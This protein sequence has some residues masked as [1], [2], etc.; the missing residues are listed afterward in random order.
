M[1]RKKDRKISADR[2][3]KV[4]VTEPMMEADTDQGVVRP[5]NPIINF[6]SIGS[7]GGNGANYNMTKHYGKG[8][9]D[10]T[11][12]AFYTVKTLLNS[13]NGTEKTKKGYL[14]GGFSELSDYLAIWHHTLSRELTHKDITPEFIE[15]FRGHMLGAGKGYTSQKI[16]YTSVKGLLTAMR[17]NGYWPIPNEAFSEIFPANPYPN[18]NRRVK[19]AKPFSEHEK[20]QL[21]VALK[22]ALKPIYAPNREEPLTGYELTVCVLAIAMQTGINTTPL[23]NMTT[24]S[25]SDHPLKSNRK[26]LTVYK[27]RGNATQLHN[28][29]KSEQ[30]EL[31]QGVKL[32]VAHIIERIT[33]L[34]KSVRDK[35]GSNSLIVYRPTGG[36]GN[37]RRTTSIYDRAL[38]Y[39]IAKLVKNYELIDEDKKTIKVN[40]SRI[41]KTFI[42]GIYELSGENILIAAKSAKHSGTGT[43]DHYL[44]AP[45]KSKRNL[46]LM[47]EIRVKELTS[48]TQPTPT[49]RCKDPIDGDKAP[50]NGTTCADF[51]ACFRCKSFVITGDDLY[52]LYSFYWAIV[53]NR[54]SFGRKDWKRYLRNVMSV[55]D[56]EVE[57]AFFEKG[58]ASH[59]QAERERARVS[60][61]P[62][63][64]NLD[65]LRVG[66]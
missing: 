11:N 62:Y 46:G 8:F 63:W 66:Q 33:A 16:V 57:P 34:N 38:S 32:D 7:K 49:G 50:K 14:S 52:R 64:I 39:N 55:I 44:E 48:D 31:V 6:P 51:L 54:D 15:G 30:V 3:K 2:F 59:L 41:R 9:D 18:S 58:M 26:L 25:L 53:R 47:G 45:E 13:K 23:L 56:T 60:P 10:I 21:V 35:L 19:G 4:H 29:R 40:L 1:A 27:A 28:L 17:N 5:I 20:R 42:N 24:D 37:S 65:M 12:R 22:Q 43:I 61:H 36:A